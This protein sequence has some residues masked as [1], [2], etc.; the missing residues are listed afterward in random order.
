L[1]HEGPPPGVLGRVVLRSVSICASCGSE[2]HHAA[3]AITMNVA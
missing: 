3:S 2:I 1:G